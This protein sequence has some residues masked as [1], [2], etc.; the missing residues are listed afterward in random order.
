MFYALILR[1][2]VLVRV[3]ARLPTMAI[4]LDDREDLRAAVLYLRDQGFN[5]KAI[6]GHSKGGTVV[7]LYSA[8]YNDVGLVINIAGR[9]FMGREV[10]RFNK[11]QL[12]ELEIN[13]KFVWEPSHLPSGKSFVVTKEQIESRASLDVLAASEKISFADFLTVHGTKDEIVPVI[14]AEEGFHSHI[15]R[16]SLCL[17][18]GARHQFKDKE[19][20]L[21]NG[22]VSW[23]SSRL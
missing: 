14:D 4:W 23:L 10:S 17:I 7:T 3:K 11:G 18:D 6:M 16:H 1:L 20:E 22:V 2:Q 5:V 8:E 19:M 15:K 21:G 13:G 9:F 12:E